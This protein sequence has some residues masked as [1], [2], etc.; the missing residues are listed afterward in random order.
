[1]CCCVYVVRS[2]LSLSLFHLSFVTTI[3]VSKDVVFVTSFDFTLPLGVRAYFRPHSLRRL[4]HHVKG[5]I[6]NAEALFPSL[7]TRSQN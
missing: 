4:V 3:A 6:A 7:G 2:F 1:M 5:H